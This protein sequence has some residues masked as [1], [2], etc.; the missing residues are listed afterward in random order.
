MKLREFAAHRTS[1]RGLLTY[2]FSKEKMN[3]AERPG[4]KN[5]E[6]KYDILRCSFNY[7]M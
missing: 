6:Y 5:D 7:K 2:I 4:V 3:S 1:V